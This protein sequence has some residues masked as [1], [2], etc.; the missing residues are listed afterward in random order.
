MLGT[1]S[2][3]RYVCPGGSKDAPPVL[4]AIGV[5]AQTDGINHERV[6]AV[7]IYCR[8]TSGCKGTA[9][10]TF[11][12]KQASTGKQI[13]LSLPGGST[14]H[15]S[16]RLL[17]RLMDPIRKSHGIAATLTAVVGSTTVSQTIVVKII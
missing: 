4:P 15:V 3:A 14:T 11:G 1:G 16:I 5:R 6:V 17:A 9:T 12:G 10:L 7:A 2:D 13:P 8:L